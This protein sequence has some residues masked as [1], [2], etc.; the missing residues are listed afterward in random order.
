[1]LFENPS[2]RNFAP[3][4][5]LA[6]DPFGDAKTV[7][8]G[9]FGLFHNQ[10]TNR[11]WSQ[12]FAKAEGFANLVRIANPPFPITSLSQLNVPVVSQ[13]FAFQFDGVKTPYMMQ[14]NLTAEREFLPETVFMAGYVGSRGVH[15]PVKS[16][17][18]IPVPEIRPDGRQFFAS[19]LPRRNRNYGN[20]SLIETAG[21]SFYHSFRFSVRR[22]LAEGFQFQASYTFSR[23]IDEGKGEMEMSYSGSPNRPQDPFNKLGDRGLS[24]V[25][26]RNNFVLNWS[27]ALPFGRHLSGAVGQLAKGWQINSIVTM[28]AGAPFWVG[29]NFDQ[30][31]TLDFDGLRPNLRP[32]ASNNP[33]L[34]TPDK[35]FDLSAFQVQE[36]GFFGTLGRNT[37]IGPG[38]A[39]VD[40]SLSKNF[41][42]TEKVDVQFRAEF[43]NVLNRANFDAPASGA[44]AF[45][46]F[47]VSQAQA[48]TLTQTTTTSRQIQFGL[49]ILF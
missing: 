26:V 45:N 40:F 11:Y 30:A 22:R 41:D 44:T 25:D 29:L 5:G 42:L 18:N 49:K 20:V 4:L 47:G 43:F 17:V 48:A 36:P 15:L 33:I 24:E 10:L 46:R 7:L 37:L 39:N 27:Y 3:R 38:L 13:V 9:G 14:W 28:A 35:Y 2:D 8:R 23:T 31:R 1:P 16:D 12:V 32:G 19:G 21:N 6:W 34:G